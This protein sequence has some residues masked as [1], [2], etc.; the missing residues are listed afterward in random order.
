MPGFNHGLEDMYNG[1]VKRMSGGAKTDFW[2]GQKPRRDAYANY[3]SVATYS[4]RMDIYE[5]EGTRRSTDFLSIHGEDLA[6]YKSLMI[7]NRS[8]FMITCKCRDACQ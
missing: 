3:L 2:T 5:P 1:L 7:D 8:E 6:A 4:Q